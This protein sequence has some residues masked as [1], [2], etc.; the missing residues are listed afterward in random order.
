MQRVGSI[1]GTSP[2]LTAPPLSRLAAA[3]SGPDIAR[4][5]LPISPLL[6]GSADIASDFYRGRFTLADC[7]VRLENAWTLARADGPPAW[8]REF[9]GLTWLKH[10]DADGRELHRV[11]ARALC[12]QLL[13]T[14]RLP[15]APQEQ[16]LIRARRFISLIAYGRMLTENAAPEFLDIYFRHA[17]REWRQLQSPGK[18]PDERLDM[19]IA[20]AY[21]V[22]G[23]GGLS[24]YRDGAFARLDAELDQQILP[25]GGHI[26][27]NPARIVGLLLD[28]IPLRRALWTGHRA[29]PT[30]L[31]A[32]IERMTPMLRFFAHGDG[33]L[34]AFQGSTGPMTDEIR[35]I[36][37]SDTALGS[38]L[39]QAPHAG[40]C[41]LAHGTALVIADT[42]AP[43]QCAG[44]LAFE[45]SDGPHRLVVNCGQPRIA[46]D[47]WCRATADAAAHSTFGLS[48]DVAA[49][50]RS[51]LLWRRPAPASRAEAKLS[52]TGD[53]SLMRGWQ[54]SPAATHNI[55]HER[56]IYLSKTGADLR[57]E[58]RI[59]PLA[60]GPAG[61]GRFH[62]RFHLHPSVKAT[63][64]K[65]GESVLLLLPNRNG[66]RFSA[67]GT[68]PTL[69]E[70]IYL[71]GQSAPRQ[72][73][74]IVLS[75]EIGRQDRINWAFK[76]IDKR[77]PGPAEP[78]ET[79]RLPF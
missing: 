72:N 46:N 31:N 35:S 45:F 38:P 57:G 59:R 29:I 9:Y 70:S 25:D 79:A 10:L 47:D 53:G 20:C 14:S 66:W 7:D 77:S 34:A 17:R 56:D 78:G 62:I 54:D 32:A 30:R 71:F 43:A 15:V 60:D 22:T 49:S 61:T 12:A 33:G 36:L 1:D 18:T 68:E 74:Q 76:R 67:R 58:D 26:S 51:R 4:L 65:D 19:A 63:L 41:R 55:M 2:G 52:V 8:R 64:S 28:L 23:L 48:S 69:E 11:F 3:I 73:Q 40:Y 75:G 24:A 16:T 27:R 44:P 21:A 39:T 5:D 42:G 13:S 6:R 37:D 50:R